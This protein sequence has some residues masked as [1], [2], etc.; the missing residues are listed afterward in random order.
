LRLAHGR[1]TVVD[2]TNLQYRARRPLLR[3]ARANRVAIVAVVFDVSLQTSLSNNRARPDRFVNEEAI[4]QHFE[5]LSR[6]RLRLNR[7]GYQN[8][9][10]LDEAAIGAVEVERIA[11]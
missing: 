9:Y 3:I 4:R 2:A 6:T 7:E 1:L 11:V 8:I 10:L 5:E